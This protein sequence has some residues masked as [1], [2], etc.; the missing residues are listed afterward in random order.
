[1]SRKRSFK[2]TRRQPQWLR[3]QWHDA[4]LGK[5]IDDP[6]N[7]H[8]IMVRAMCSPR[9]EIAAILGVDRTRRCCCAKT[10]ALGDRHS[11]PMEPWRVFQPVL[12]AGAASVILAHNHPNGRRTPSPA[13]ILVTMK[14][15]ELGEALGVPV[16]DHWIV[17]RRAL[18]SLALRGLMVRSRAPWTP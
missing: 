1:M 15:E 11:V 18:V 5:P 14:L 4:P 10:I 3:H 8:P 7:W 9:W 17:T 13:D 2:S 12:R 6:A 16:L